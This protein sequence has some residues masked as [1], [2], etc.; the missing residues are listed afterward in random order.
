VL[1]ASKLDVQKNGQLLVS[2]LLMCTCFIYVI[3]N[4]TLV[5]ATK[6]VAKE[7]AGS[8]S[9]GEAQVDETPPPTTS[10]SA[11]GNKGRSAAKPRARAV[12]KK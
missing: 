7:G 8:D 4:N 3:F 11:R 6:L 5:Y 10:K 9:V 12:K 1:R 2:L